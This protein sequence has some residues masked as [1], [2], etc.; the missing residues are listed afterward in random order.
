MQ[1][2]VEWKDGTGKTQDKQDQEL[3]LGEPTNIIQDLLKPHDGETEGLRVCVS[4]VLKSMCY[5][6]LS[7]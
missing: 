3:E 2:K 4:R 6:L 7:I 1:E 5:S